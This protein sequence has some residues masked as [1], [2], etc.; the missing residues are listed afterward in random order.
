MRMI[1]DILRLGDIMNQTKRIQI[2]RHYLL[3]YLNILIR[4]YLMT[5]LFTH[6]CLM[7]VYVQGHS[8]EPQIADG[9]IGFANVAARH[10]FG[11]HRYDIVLIQREDGE[12]WIKRVIGLPNDRIEVRQHT[13]YINGIAQMEEYVNQAS[14]MADFAPIE[15]GENEIFVMGDNRDDSYDSRRVGSIALQDVIGKDLYPLP[16]LSVGE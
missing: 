16:M 1:L 10:L 15:V 7:P 6:A 9:T 13:L 11:I 3:T 2:M 14:A 12:I 8:M 5:Y 4:A